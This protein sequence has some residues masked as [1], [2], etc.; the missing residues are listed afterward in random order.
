MLVAGSNAKGSGVTSAIRDAANA[1]GASFN[2]LLATARVESG[3]D[4][5]A[6]ANTSSAGGLFQFIDQ[7]W[8]ATLKTAGSGLGYGRYAQAITQ[9]DAGR[10]QVNDPTMRQAIMALR[11]DPT[12]NAAMA[13]AFTQSNAQRLKQKIGRAPTDGELYMAHF[14][15]AAGA[16]RLISLASSTP[17]A[18]AASLF[19]NAAAANRSI[20]YDKQG[21]A[22]SVSQVYDGLTRRFDVALAASSK[23]MS[24]TALAPQTARTAQVA[25]STSSRTVSPVAG[26]ASVETAPASTPGPS[27]RSLFSS[28]DQRGP[29]SSVVQDL[30]GAPS[31]PASGPTRGISSLFSDKG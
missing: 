7:T 6:A 13:G 30:W 4:P 11:K 14:F 3:L 26:A 19:P 12:A 27:F 23:S 10:Y 2:Y 5:N 9:N 31:S 15:G 8:L 22:R 1:T 17:N 18:S 29:L 21:S 28:T 20:F 24:A 25:S 16:G